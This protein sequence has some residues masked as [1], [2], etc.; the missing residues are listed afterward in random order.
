MNSSLSKPVVIVIDRK[1]ET[2]GISFNPILILGAII[3]AIVV[4]VTSR[5]NKKDDTPNTTHYDT[6]V[7][8]YAGGVVETSY[9]V[10]LPDE[11]LLIKRLTEETIDDSFIVEYYDEYYSDVYPSLR[12]FVQYLINAIYANRGHCFDDSDVQGFF[13]SKKWYVSKGAKVRWEDFSWKEQHNLTV[14]TEMRKEL[15]E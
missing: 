6:Q 2:R 9:V 11:E 5:T 10:T 8:A 3:F 13:D 15:K 14:L 12:R 4:L 1:V 7:E